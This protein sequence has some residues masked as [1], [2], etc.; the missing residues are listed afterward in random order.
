MPPTL[1]GALARLLA[2]AVARLRR[3]S[4]EG[5]ERRLRGLLL[6]GRL[7]ARKLRLGRG[8]A[9]EGRARIRL[10][11]G[12]SLKDSVFVGAR[13]AHGSVDIGPNT[14]V[15][16]Q[17][18]LFGGG[19][20]RLGAGCAVAAGVIVYSQSNQYRADPARPVLD[21]P[22][23]HAPV[24]VGDDVWIGAGAVLLPGVTVGDHAVIGAGAVVTS[25]VAPWTVVAGVPARVVTTRRSA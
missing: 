12:V 4:P 25:D 14:R 11:D 21:Q 2:P 6:G 17:T 19:G 16:R 13:G 20:I 24:H 23:V 8:V 10:G 1:A 3:A 7:G 9:L 5:V 15:D 22:L 18:Q